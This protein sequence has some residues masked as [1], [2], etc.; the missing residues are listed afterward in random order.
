MDACISRVIDRLSRGNL[1]G[2]S[3]SKADNNN[4]NNNNNNN[5]KD[6][7]KEKKKRAST[8]IFGSYSPSNPFQPRDNISD[9]DTSNGS[10]VNG[11]LQRKIRY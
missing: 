6:K 1:L 5:K 8:M 10:K 2:D 11:G 4:N 7:K 9:S 3:N